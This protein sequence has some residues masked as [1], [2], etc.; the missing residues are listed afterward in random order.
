MLDGQV[1]SA[2]DYHD[3]GL[4]A[5]R[6]ARERAVSL[7]FSDT[8]LVD[9]ASGVVNRGCHDSPHEGSHGADP[10]GN[11]EVHAVGAR[12]KN[13]AAMMKIFSSFFG[14]DGRRLAAT[15]DAAAA[16]DA[17]AAVIASSPRR[18]SAAAAS[19]NSCCK[20]GSGGATALA[21]Q[22]P[23]SLFMAAHLI[24]YI[25]PQFYPSPVSM[26]MNGG[27]WLRDLLTCLVL[28][29]RAKPKPT[30]NPQQI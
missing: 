3:G 6:V 1:L 13:F 19:A 4:R 12:R 27:C 5:E 17:A 22:P 21:A 23:K 25:W 28:P 14:N 30:T 9:F 29:A 18:L 16:R 2:E 8:S 20:A 24:D 7:S 26:T 10:C 11:G 15:T